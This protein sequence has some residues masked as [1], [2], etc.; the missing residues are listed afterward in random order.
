MNYEPRSIADHIDCLA[1]LTGA[2][3][4]FVMQIK[5]LFSRKGISLHEDAE[6]YIDAL[7]EAF[8]REE[9]IRTSAR[10]VHDNVAR[11]QDNFGRIGR[12]YVRQLQQLKRMQSRSR[13]KQAA[14]VSAAPAAKP[15]ETSIPG[16]DHR[17]LVT[18][19]QLD[20][21]P[22]VPGPEEIQ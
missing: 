4:S 22:M 2:P 17:T 15:Q 5:D 9:S 20:S 18:R 12:A 1:R 14:S 6:P 13:G 10:R 19:L 16:G 7:E 3:R 11:L 8:R 21:L